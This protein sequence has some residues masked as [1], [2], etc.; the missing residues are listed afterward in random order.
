MPVGTKEGIFSMCKKA[1]IGYNVLTENY[2]T[3]IRYAAKTSDSFSVVT[4]QVKPF[5]IVAPK[6]RHDEILNSISDYLIKQVVGVK[7]WPGTKTSAN[8]MV[9][10]IYRMVKSTRNWLNESPNLFVYR[11]DLP[12]DICFYRDGK[13]WMYATTHEHDMTIINPTNEDMAFFKTIETA[14]SSGGGKS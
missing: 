12:E 11:E 14:M 7:S 10:N 6:C 5:S 9:L 4:E 8:H 2:R 3:I 13:P 1:K